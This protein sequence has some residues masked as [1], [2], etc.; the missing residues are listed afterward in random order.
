MLRNLRDAA[1]NLLPA[2]DTFARYRDGAEAPAGVGG[3]ERRRPHYEALLTELESLGIERSSLY[4]AWDFTVAS[5][6]N[7]AGRMLTMRDD[8]F[9]HVTD[10]T[11]AFEFTQVEDKR[12]RAASDG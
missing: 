6:Y 5:M 9:T 1:G 2:P 8:G 11:P 4:L 12:R 7:I 3:F 10:G